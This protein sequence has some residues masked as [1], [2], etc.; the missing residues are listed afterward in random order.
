[1][2]SL[3]L[4]EIAA[5]SRQPPGARTALSASAGVRVRA[6][7]AVRAPSHSSWTWLGVL[8]LIALSYCA[9]GQT[10]P[11]KESPQLPSIM[12]NA[13]GQ[14]I[15]TPRQW[16]KQR[17]VLRTEWL[18]ILGEFPKKKAPLKTEILETEHLPEFTR[19]H[20][21]YQVEDS[22]FTDGCLLTPRAARG[23]LP[24]VVVFHPT[25]PLQARGVAG[26]EPSYD[27]EKWHGVQLVQ[28]G[29]VVWC[30]RN[31]INTDGADWKGNAQRVRER[32]PDWTG[33]TRMVW[34][35]IRAAD[36]LES[37][38]NVDRQ[39]IGCLGHSLGGK[40][41]LYAMAFDERYRAG[42]S[43]EGGIGLR[44]SNWDSVWYLG[45]Q[46]NQPGFTREHHEM[47]ALAAPRAFLLL[48]GDSADTDA[49]GAF[50]EAVQPVYALLGAAEKVRLLNH[51]Q[52]HRYPP[53]ARAAA[54]E[55]LDRHLKKAE[56]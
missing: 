18:K 55:F 15:T 54:E 34:D 47:L 22:L 21:R 28:R 12:I 43:S 19:Q 1:M 13:K 9:S 44:F 35:A 29:Y 45:D 8:L 7:K 5:S 56:R 11:A 2:G 53:E 42:V 32:H 3:R 40:E 10:A 48:A 38:P 16:R 6:D 23:S 50:I 20:L 52:G 25:T 31:Y 27:V 17:E 24:A 41:V 26:L 46:I 37:L 4:A 49:S 51:R 36:F 39:R 14:P 30:P 33:M